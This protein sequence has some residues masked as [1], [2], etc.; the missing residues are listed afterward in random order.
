MNLNIITIALDAMPFLPAQLFCF[1]ALPPEVDW[2]WW[3]VEGAADNVKCTAWCQKPKPRLSVDGTTEF[4]AGLAKSHRRV[5]HTTQALWPGKV[6][7]YNCVLRRL[8]EPCI[9]MQIDADEIWMPGNIEAVCAMLSDPAEGYTCAR[10]HC[11]FF[12]GPRL[13]TV[14]RNCYGANP[15]EWLRAWRYEPGMTFTSHEPPFLTG[16][17]GPKEKCAERDFCAQ[18]GIGFDHYSYAFRWQVEQ[19]E[20]YYGYADAVKRWERLQAYQGPWP[21]RLQ[22]FFHWADERAMVTKL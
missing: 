5:H 14:G 3:I 20:Q 17:N 13:I 10:F 22:P 6:S 21:T 12:V 4:L 7:M 11:R 1:N 2:H 9:L 15:G 18:W 8:K 16:A 19:K